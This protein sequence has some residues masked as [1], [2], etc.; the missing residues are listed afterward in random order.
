MSLPD[1]YAHSARRYLCG[2]FS[3]L[4]QMI[5]AALSLYT[6]DDRPPQRILDLGTGSGCILLSLLSEFKE[7]RG[8]GVDRSPQALQVARI[9]AHRMRLT[10]RTTFI[11]RYTTSKQH[12]LSSPLLA[13]AMGRVMEVNSTWGHCAQ[14]LARQGGRKRALR[15]GGKQP[16]LHTA[17][18]PGQ[19]RTRC[20][21]VRTC[22]PPSPSG[23]RQ[24]WRM[25]T[26]L[27]LQF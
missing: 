22:A 2:G 17:R 7:A 23:K 24:Q 5:D 16:A 3:G 15:L 19:P 12:L 18:R 21:G 26:S 1:A 13:S 4:D 11:E 25:L 8:V 10:D 14:R 6:K 27:V 9:N 20:E